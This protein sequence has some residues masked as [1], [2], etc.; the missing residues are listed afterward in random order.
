MKKIISLLLAAGLCLSFAACAAKDASDRAEEPDPAPSLPAEPAPVSQPVPAEEPETV[1]TQIDGVTISLLQTSYPAGVKNLVLL[2]DNATDLTLGYGED[3]SMQKYTDGAW[4][5]I[6][7]QE[8]TIVD[9]VLYMVPPHST[10][11]MPYSTVMLTRSL[12]EGLYRLTGG[13]LWM[14]ED[15]EER[16]TFPAWHIDFRVTS[17]A[18]PAPDYALYI[19]I[20]PVLASEEQIPVQFI[21]TTGKD[22]YVLDIPHLERQNDAGEWEEVPYREG[23]GF[24]GT[25]STLPAGVRDWSE[26]I[27]VLWD[28]LEEGQYRLSYAVGPDFDTD[29]TVYGEFTV[30][31]PELCGLPLAEDFQA[32]E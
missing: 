29:Q 6:D 22:G 11:T 10:R 28:A 8:N 1:W 2:L 12:D 18:P 17:D 5:Q 24:C 3:F 30:C 14:W 13:E 9:D 4:R 19:P 7:F 25:P 26:D 20:Q 32:E 15:Q 21:N 31:G 27:S 16:E 23:I